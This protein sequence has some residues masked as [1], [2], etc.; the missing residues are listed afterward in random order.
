MLAERR[1]IRRAPKDLHEGPG[2]RLAI[3]FHDF[4][5]NVMTTSRKRQESPKRLNDGNACQ[6]YPDALKPLKMKILQIGASDDYNK[7]QR[8]SGNR[9]SIG[10]D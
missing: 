7:G 6:R 1:Q 4:P 8:C 9:P 3:N 10:K 2:Y 5:I